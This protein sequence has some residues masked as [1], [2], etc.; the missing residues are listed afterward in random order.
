MKS[1][2]IAVSAC[3]SLNAFAGSDQVYEKSF[4]QTM[5]TVYPNVTKALEGN[6]FKIVY[7]V[8]IGNNLKS[9]SEKLGAAYNQNHLESTKSIVFC[10]GILAN[11]IGN[12]DPSMLALCPLHVTLV[13]K[14]G[15]TSVL[16][17]KPSAV[18]KGS[19]AEQAAKELEAKVVKALEASVDAK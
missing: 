6:G 4:K 5:D 17:V 13:Q 15:A 16:F 9:L 18:A 12:A 1:L 8:D 11:K 3:L 7:E 2:I 14:D 19:P 10:N